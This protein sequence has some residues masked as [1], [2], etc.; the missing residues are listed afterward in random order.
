[1][2]AIAGGSLSIITDV[3]VAKYTFTDRKLLDL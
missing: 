2:C 3:V 1:M